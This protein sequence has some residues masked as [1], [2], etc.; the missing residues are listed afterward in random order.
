MHCDHDVENLIYS[1]SYSFDF[2]ML[3]TE[4]FSQDLRWH[5]LSYCVVNYFS[6][7][8][9]PIEGHYPGNKSTKPYTSYELRNIRDQLLDRDDRADIFSVPR[10]VGGAYTM[11]DPLKQIRQNKANAVSTSTGQF[12][13]F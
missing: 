11:V 5:S 8:S 6:P 4:F 3:V 13:C 12:L 2:L 7:V 1:I 9:L 10:P